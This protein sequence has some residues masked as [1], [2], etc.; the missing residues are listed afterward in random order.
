MFFIIH[1]PS[2]LLIDLPAFSH[3]LKEDHLTYKSD[4]KILDELGVAFSAGRPCAAITFPQ[5]EVLVM[6]IFKQWMSIQMHELAIFPTS[7]TGWEEVFGQDSSPFEIASKTH[8]TNLR[9]QTSDS[10][11]DV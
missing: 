5:L 10:S 11:E 2:R 3:V 6:C 9:P 7:R 8:T 4:V 1:C